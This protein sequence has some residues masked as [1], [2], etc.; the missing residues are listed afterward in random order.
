MTLEELKA[1]VSKISYRD[2][3][4]RVLTKGDGFL[5]Q[6]RFMAPDSITGEPALQSCRKW[7]ISSFATK[8]EV[9]GT[10]YKAIETAVIH[11]AREEFKY[12]GRAI[13]NPHQDPDA[14]ADAEQK[15]DA[16]KPSLLEAIDQ[17]RGGPAPIGRLTTI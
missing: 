10:A 9:V 3:E 1:I 15:L 7:Y 13:F 6:V 14:L 4:F 16:R 17:A 8:N 5:L 12:R 11:E 2:W